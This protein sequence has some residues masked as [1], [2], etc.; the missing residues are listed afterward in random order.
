MLQEGI[1]LE[2]GMSSEGFEGVDKVEG[3]TRMENEEVYGS[4]KKIKKEEG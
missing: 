1:R 3:R 2:R 4:D